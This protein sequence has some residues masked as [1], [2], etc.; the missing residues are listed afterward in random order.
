MTLIEPGPKQS[1][2]RR[3]MRWGA[4]AACVL[5]G[6]YRPARPDCAVSCADGAPCPNGLTCGATDRL[7]HAGAIECSAAE[8]PGDAATGT[9]NGTGAGGDATLGVDAAP[10]IDAN[11]GYC[12]PQSG[13]I[14]CY[15]FEN[16]ARNALPGLDITVNG[17]VQFPTDGEVGRAAAFDTTTTASIA[18][19]PRL[20]LLT[21]T[22]EAWVNPSQI[23]A[24][25]NTSLVNRYFHYAM[26]LDTKGDPVCG[27]TP[28]AGGLVIAAT[29]VP[30]V[31]DRWSHVACT[32]DGTNLRTYVN[33]LNPASTLTGAGPVATGG[34]EGVSIGGAAPDHAN[35]LYIGQLDELRIFSRVRTS[36]EICMDAGLASCM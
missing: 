7:C 5:A 21:F 11:P 8:L 20:D 3:A 33:G 25:G 19:D 30:L 32:F 2:R 31:L 12:A 22:I 35:D 17:N 6:C 1:V 14:G 34:M 9:G 4:V 28:S 27:Y 13:L 29:I 18:V 16:T 15:Q 23:S 24:N 36:Q 26:V 10:G